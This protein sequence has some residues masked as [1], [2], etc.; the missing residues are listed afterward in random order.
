MGADDLPRLNL[1]RASVS[2]SSVRARNAIV[3]VVCGGF[4][5]EVPMRADLSG[6][7]DKAKEL[8]TVCPSCKSPYWNKPRQAQTTGRKK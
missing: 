3:R 8:P 4:A 2:D 6:S 7:L 1:A 5:R